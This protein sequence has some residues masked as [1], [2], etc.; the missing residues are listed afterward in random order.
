MN[1]PLALIWLDVDL[2]QSTLDVL[3][4]VFT[5]LDPRG[6]LFSHEFADEF[7]DGEGLIES[8]PGE[9]VARAIRLFF[10]Q[11]G[12]EYRAKFLTGCLATVVPGAAGPGLRI[13]RGAHDFLIDPPSEESAD[14]APDTSIG[15]QGPHHRRPRRDE[16]A[17]DRD[18]LWVLKNQLSEECDRLRRANRGLESER[19][20]LLEDLTVA[21]STMADLQAS[22]S[23][24]LGR[25]LTWF[26]RF[27]RGWPGRSDD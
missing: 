13:S 26:P 27:V 16:L 4:N 20:I 23:F 9:D 24:R 2:Y 14:G 21:R 17:M 11:H 22:V 8:A 3:G 10:D 12:V 19:K 15:N 18:E 7:I 5:R 25:A 1:D 6:L